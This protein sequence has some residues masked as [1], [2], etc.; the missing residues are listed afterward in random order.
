MSG[1]TKCAWWAEDPANHGFD[2]AK[3]I[4][5]DLG[6]NPQ[7]HRTKGIKQ[8]EIEVDDA[9]SNGGPTKLGPTF[10]TGSM[11]NGI[12]LESNHYDKLQNKPARP[13]SYMQCRPYEL[14]TVLYWDNARRFYGFYAEI[15]SEQSQNALCSIWPAGKSLA[16]GAQP[17]GSWWID[18]QSSA[19]P[20]EKGFTEIG[21]GPRDPKKGALFLDSPTI[22]NL[23]LA[24]PK[25]PPAAGAAFYPRMR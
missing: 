2:A 22:T 3:L 4:K 11:I 23:Q 12:W 25:L 13:P 18:L 24:S 20:M 14:T 17:A 6:K 7:S 8:D 19:H 10:P 21:L 16:P 1:H 15:T 5:S 9:P